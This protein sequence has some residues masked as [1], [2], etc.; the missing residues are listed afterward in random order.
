VCGIEPQG[1]RLVT[2]LKAI[3]VQFGGLIN[4]APYKGMP[5]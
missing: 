4:V 5:A 3:V 1:S 2:D